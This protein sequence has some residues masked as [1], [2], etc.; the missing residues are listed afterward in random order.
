M[1]AAL[2]WSISE[3]T[4]DD[5]HEHE[6]RDAHAD[7][8][9]QYLR[10][11]LLLGGPPPPPL[12]SAAYLRSEPGRATLAACLLRADSSLYMF[13]CTVCYRIPS[14]VAA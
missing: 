2:L 3:D 5:R 4:V 11:L 6:E 14:T 12:R 7:Q 9:Q 8:L 13:I 10:G 1:F